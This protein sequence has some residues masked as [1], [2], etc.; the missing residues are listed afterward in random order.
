MGIFYLSWPTQSYLPKQ[1]R[2]KTQINA[3]KIDPLYYAYLDPFNT[4]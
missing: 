2:K 1:A 4:G 3:N